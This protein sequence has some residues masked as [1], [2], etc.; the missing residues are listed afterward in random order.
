[1]TLDPVRKS[2]TVPLPQ[3]RAFALFTEGLGSWWPGESHSVSAGKGELPAK[4]EMEPREGGEIRETAPD[5]STHIWGQVKTW[6]QSRRVVF[7][8][9]P[10]RGPDRAGEVEVTFAVADSGTRVELIHTGFENMDSENVASLRG[11][12]DRGWDLVLGERFANAARALV[13]A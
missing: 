6:E 4:V 2:L 11:N 1:M 3:E 10:G 9:H 7:S 5:G 12:Y 8:W 13:A